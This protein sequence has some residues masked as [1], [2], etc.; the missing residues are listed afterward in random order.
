MCLSTIYLDKKDPKHVLAEEASSVT[1]HG[2]TV[3]IATLFGEP[4]TV[5]G[6]APGEI[7]LL[8]HYVVL[9]K[10]GAAYAAKK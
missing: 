6:Y 10:S 3:K 7:N 2:N 4:R 9:V 1:A 8:E 5:K